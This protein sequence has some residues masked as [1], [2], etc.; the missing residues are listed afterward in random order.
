M[1]NELPKLEK[2]IYQTLT[3]DSSLS[4]LVDSRV[5]SYQVPRDAVFPLVQFSYL[6]G[7]DVQ[8]LGS[9]RLLSRPVYQVKTIGRN[10]LLADLMNFK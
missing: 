6:A 2:F 3:S 9:A 8:G 7:R 5:Y 1:S 4:F 10:N